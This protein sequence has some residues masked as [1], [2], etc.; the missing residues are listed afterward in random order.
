MGA[1]LVCFSMGGEMG[2]DGFRLTVCLLFF[3][4]SRELILK[5]IFG[6]LFSILPAM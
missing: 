3:C 2:V 6:G 4:F 5:G 1:G